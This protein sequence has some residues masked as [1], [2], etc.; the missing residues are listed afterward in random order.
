[1][2]KKA[3]KRKKFSLLN[4][5]RGLFWTNFDYILQIH[6]AVNLRPLAEYKPSY[7]IF[8]RPKIGILRDPR[9][10]HGVGQKLRRDFQLDLSSGNK[11]KSGEFKFLQRSRLKKSSI[12]KGSSE[13][14]K[15]RFQFDSL[16]NLQSNL[17]LLELLSTCFPKAPQQSND[18]LRKFTAATTFP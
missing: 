17:G 7:Y 4:F 8:Y 9:P 13:P 11:N 16:H 5:K 1:M 2:P 10:L 6:S 15:E 12:A 14:T 18:S 3:L